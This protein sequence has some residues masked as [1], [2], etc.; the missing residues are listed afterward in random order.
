V[1]IALHTAAAPAYFA[2]VEDHGYKMLDGG[3]WANNPIMNAVVDVMACYDVLPENIKVLSIGTGEN[4]VKIGKRQMAGG[5][6]AWGV[7]L[8]IP[9][10]FRLAARAQSKNVLGQAYLLLGKPNVIRVDL[11]EREQ[12][13]DLDDVIRA[14]AEMPS[15]ARAHAEANGA[16]IQQMFLFGEAERFTNFGRN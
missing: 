6:F 11:D 3:L 5:K 4:T 14:K 1:D 15:L 12:H 13:M 8:D 7:S 2:A 9:I 10:L 16:L